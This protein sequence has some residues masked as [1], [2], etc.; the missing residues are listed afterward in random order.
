MMS[1]NDLEYICQWLLLSQQFINLPGEE[2]RERGEFEEERDLSEL[3][4]A[5]KQ[6]THIRGNKSGLH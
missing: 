3:W 5:D 6:T 1:W 4:H 2:C